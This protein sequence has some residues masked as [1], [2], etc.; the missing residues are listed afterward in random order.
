MKIILNIFLG[1]NFLFCES[2][3]KETHN[4]I[5]N[6][7]LNI[8]AENDSINKFF[9]YYV[10]AQN[11]NNSNHFYIIDIISFLLTNDDTYIKDYKLSESELNK[12]KE[13]IGIT[14]LQFFNRLRLENLSKLALE[15]CKKHRINDLN[16]C[17]N[18]IKYKII[19]ISI[20]RL[21]KEAKIKEIIKQDIKPAYPKGII[22]FEIIEKNEPLLLSEEGR[23]YRLE[24]CKT[25][26]LDNEDKCNEL[27]YKC[28][29]ELKEEYKKLINNKKNKLNINILYD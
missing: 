12:M 15:Q 7:N 16:E 1:V 25:N 23:Q 29:K 13:N 19:K 8:E 14:F 28:I 6:K 2:N 17:K 20:N 4:N 5:F 3:Q 22:S 11:P 18:I 21:N 10:N 27:F 9:Y 24:I 26:D